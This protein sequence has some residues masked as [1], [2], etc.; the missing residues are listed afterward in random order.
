MT[1][2]NR[3]KSTATYIGEST[4]VEPP[5]FPIQ[6]ELLKAKNRFFAK[7]NLAKFSIHLTMLL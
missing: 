2:K 7:K 4:V 3:K 1:S 6:S 5:F